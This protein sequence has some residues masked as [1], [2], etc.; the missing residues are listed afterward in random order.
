MDLIS[1]IINELMDYDKS[2]SGPLLKTKVLAARIKNDKLINWVES[3]LSGF[4]EGVPLPNY[5][6]SKSTLMGSFLNG[7]M[8]YKSTAIPASHLKKDQLDDLTK[9]ESRDSISSI[10]NLIGE[11]G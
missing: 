5:R 7:N 6:E 1:D 3:E 9:I 10:E 8:Q 2:I 4:A 11:K